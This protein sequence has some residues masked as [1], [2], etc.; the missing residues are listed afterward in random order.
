M[1]GGEDMFRML[2]YHV[3]GDNLLPHGL[4]NYMQVITCSIQD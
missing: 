3:T 4:R 1:F 2:D